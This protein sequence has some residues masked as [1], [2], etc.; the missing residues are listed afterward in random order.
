[1]TMAQPTAEGSIW[2]LDAR[3]RP[4]GEKGILSCSLTAYETYYQTR[5]QL[6]EAQALTRARPIAGPLQDGFMELAQ[7]VWRIAGQRPD[8][9]AQIDAMLQR[10]R[11]DRG[12]SSDELDFKT[13]KGGVIETEFL[14]QALQMR[15][16]IWNPQ[17]TGALGQL[18]KAGIMAEGDAE[19]LRKHYEYLRSIGSIL[20]RWENKSISILPAD[21]IEQEKLAARAGARSLD[22]FA[23]AYRD[24][25]AGINAIYSRYVR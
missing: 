9:F 1:V 17:M 23:Q 15:A 24:A 10:I 25:R 4:D 7:R 16:G 20:R 13:G 8:L 3:L 19:A 21:K 22:A 14:V 2:T 11:R 12:S 6:W 18:A 5:A